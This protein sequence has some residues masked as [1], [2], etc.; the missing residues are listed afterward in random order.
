MWICGAFVYIG[1]QSTSATNIALIYAATPVAIAVVGRR[2]AAA[3]A[4]VRRSAGPWLLALAGV[5]FVIAKG[6]LDNLLGC[7]SASATAGSWPPHM[8]WVA[9]SVLLKLLAR[10]AGPGRA[11]GGH[12]RRRRAGA[13]AFT[14]WRLAARAAPAVQRCKAL[15]LMRRRRGAAGRAELR[16]YSFLQRELGASRTALM[17]YLAPVYGAAQCLAGA[18]RG[19]RLVPRGRRRTDPAQHRVGDSAHPRSACGASPSRGAPP[20]NRQSRIRGGRWVPS[21]ALLTQSGG[22][23]SICPG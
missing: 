12:H 3:R 8:A 5:L 2:Q 9:Y 23:R 18:G 1:G 17:L 6:D 13:A 4:H 15:G 16:A 20:A 11:P 7:A 19:A 22:M 14:R 21:L 10:R